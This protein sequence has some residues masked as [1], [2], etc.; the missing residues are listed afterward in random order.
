ML[1]VERDHHRRVLAALALVDRAGVRESE[2]VEGG[3]GIDHDP[4]VEVDR[5]PPFGALEGEDAADVTVEDA[6]VVVVALLHHA[7]ADPQ[8]QTAAAHFVALRIEQ[9]LQLGVEVRGAEQTAA[10][11]R[12]HLDIGARLE[13][14]GLRNAF[15]DQLAHGRQDRL[16]L[17][18]LDEEEVVGAFGDPVPAGASRQRCQSVAHSV[19]V[20]DDEALAR[21]AED[22]VEARDLDDAGVDEVGEQAAGSDRRQ[23]VDVADQNQSRAAWQR[24][25]QRAGER[26]VEHRRLVHHQHVEGQRRVRPPREAM[27]VGLV[28]EQPMDRLG[29]VTG[30]L[31][32][33]LGGATGG[34]GQLHS[35][36]LGAQDL[37]DAAHQGRLPG[38]RAAGEHEQPRTER[39]GQGT[40]LTARQLEALPLLEPL[41]GGVDVERQRQ[42]GLRGECAQVPRE[43]R[44]GDH[45]RAQAEPGLVAARSVNR[46]YLALVQEVG[47]HRLEPWRGQPE[48]LARAVEQVAAPL[49]DVAAVGGAPQDVQQAGGDPLRRLGR[50]AEIARN[51]V[52]GA[53]ADAGH[54]ARQAVGLLADDALRVVAVALLDLRR[55]VGGDAVA[56]EKDQRLA[57]RMRRLPA[58]D[59]ALRAHPSDARDLGEA[60]WVAIDHVERVEAEG[61]DQAFRGRWSDAGQQAGGQVPLDAEE[62]R[63]PH[64]LEALGAELLAVPMV[65]RPAS[66]EPYGFAGLDAQQVPGG[67]LRAAPA[68][69]QAHD[70]PAALLVGVHDPLDHALQAFLLAHRAI[71]RRLLAW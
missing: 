42:L 14:E 53:E 36:R 13:T 49:V 19:R 62:G 43:R 38:A 24:A 39:L 30:R 34:C 63:R 56:L 67:G 8:H 27:A 48:E 35:L 5:R 16:R 37:D 68:H 64:R 10:H 69:L 70:A 41:D 1:R 47:E 26:D 55:Q 57:R 50:D 12:Q 6:E 32:Q 9:R 66:L 3:E 71:L 44:L 51:A 46:L 65:A 40:A 54:L 15:G 2:S 31:G 7:I 59:D 58:L 61:R 52:G 17:L 45:Q 33:P 18:A 4:A 23:L 60:L 25:D 28:L 20:G 22:L 29:V 21:L 11:R